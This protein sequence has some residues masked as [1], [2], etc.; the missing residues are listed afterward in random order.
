MN[1]LVSELDVKKDGLSGGTGVSPVYAQD[2]RGTL[3]SPCKDYSTRLRTLGL[4]ASPVLA[5]CVL[6]LPAETEGATAEV[7]P[8]HG[9]PALFIDGN[10]A[11][12]LMYSGGRFGPGNPVV[13]HGA[14]QLSNLPGYYGGRSVRTRRSFG[15]AFTLEA[16]VCVKKINGATANILFMVN[17]SKAGSYFFHLSH[18]S[19][20]NVVHLWKA[21]PGNSNWDKWFTLPLHWKEGDSVRLKL[22]VQGDKV[23]GYANGKLVG[24]KVDGKPLPPAPLTVSAYHSSSTVNWIRITGP[25]RKILLEDDFSSVRP[26]NWYGLRDPDVP[27][28]EEAGLRIA[29]VAVG[30]KSLWQGPGSYDF[31]RLDESIQGHLRENPKSYGFIRLQL[32]PPAWW[33]ADHP[34]DVCVN[35]VAA[36]LWYASFPSE[37]WL[38]EAGRAVGDLLEHIE[39]AEYG[40]R[41]IGYNMLYGFGPEWEHPSGPTFHDYSPVA[42]KAFQ[43]WL[44]AKYE[45]DAALKAAWNQPQVTLQTAAVPP[46]EVRTAGDY[47]EFFDP[48][49]RGAYL[50]DYIR[51]NDESIVDATAHFAHIIKTRTGRKRIVTTHY[52]YHFLGYGPINYNQRGH[53]A[54]DRLLD[55]ADVDAFASAYQ[56][57]VRQA[58]GSTVP[59]TTVGS[60]RAHGKL[61]WLEDDTR[62]HLAEETASYGRARNLWETLNILKRN[63]AYAVSEAEPLWYLDWGNGWHCDKAIMDTVA[64]IVAISNEALTKDR[65][66]NAQIAVIVNQRSALY[67]RASD[68]LTMPVLCHQYFEHLPRIGAPFDTYLV[69]DLDRIPDYKLYVFLDTFAL[70]EKEKALIRRK[71]CRGGQAA[72][73]IYAPGYVTERGLSNQSM[74]ET[75]GMKLVSM[76]VA[77]QLRATLC[78]L[79]DPVT[80]HC[81]PGLEWGTK[82]PIGPIITCRDPEA[83]VLGMLHAVPGVD[84]RGRFKT[85][86][87]FEPTLAVKRMK[88][89]TSIWCGVP[90]LPAVLLRGIAKSAGVH[91]YDDADD[92]VCANRVMLAV[93]TRYAG[94]R[95]IRLPRACKVVDAFTDQVIAER[96]TSFDVQLKQYETRMWWLDE[97]SLPGCR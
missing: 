54:I 10:L 1:E 12:G 64:K 67:L 76:D 46:A 32:N 23:A 41:I 7:K 21:H 80:R 14:M 53:H 73:W 38:E 84:W 33:L 81:P 97:P 63:A 72:L 49:K 75:T 40:R 13:L 85:G 50:A 2:A 92:F 15:T 51:F 94:K 62:T 82:K 87:E 28:F 52:G 88:D 56:Y 39:A 27:T 70:N 44:R 59:I 95:T 25:E 78:D 74:S 66:R 17:N 91:I 47:Y 65:R 69:E 30:L 58:G 93:H 48:A 31:K 24:E 89:W 16:E 11:N 35:N 71:V 83:K 55:C 20:A 42:R 34:D 90:D 29:K 19:T 68:A 6:L 36:K 8:L 26:Q 43:T 79:D 45:T 5:I 96:A 4:L 18:E 61:W 57:R 60:L 22:V 3:N 37:T 77:G 9:A 86:S